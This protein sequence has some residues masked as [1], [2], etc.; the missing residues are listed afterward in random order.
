M[1]EVTAT[2]AGPERIE[3]L[4]QYQDRFTYEE[5]HIF[6]IQIREDMHEYWL[7]LR[8]LLKMSVSLIPA[9]AVKNFYANY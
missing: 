8:K 5:W 3:K 2:I 4:V 9:Y 1:Q 7:D 6:H